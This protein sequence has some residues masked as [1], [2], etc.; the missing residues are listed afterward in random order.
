MIEIKTE[1]V[2]MELPPVGGW[3]PDQAPLRCKD[4][5]KLYLRD[6]N[7]ANIVIYRAPEILA[8]LRLG[9]PIKLL[10]NLPEGV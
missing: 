4:L 3:N 9:D 6:S 10:L 5:G 7:G 1:I 2:A 8:P